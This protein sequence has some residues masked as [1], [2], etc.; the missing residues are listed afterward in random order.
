MFHLKFC[1][2]DV[3]P[4]VLHNQLSIMQA[5]VHSKGSFE[6]IGFHWYLG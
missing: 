5:Q 6:S 2:T 3:S 1:I 4:K